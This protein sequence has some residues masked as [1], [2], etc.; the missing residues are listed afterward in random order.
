[1]LEAIQIVNALT[2]ILLLLYLSAQ[3]KR[4]LKTCN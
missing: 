4:M 1:M 3:I 2:G